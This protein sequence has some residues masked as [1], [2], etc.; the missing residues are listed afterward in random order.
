MRAE[1]QAADDIACLY[2]SQVL[3]EP[4]ECRSSQRTDARSLVRA[5]ASREYIIHTR[6]SRFLTTLAF[7]L[8]SSVVSVLNSLTTIMRAPPSLFGYLI[9]AAP[10]PPSSACNSAGAMTLLLHY[11]LVL[12]GDLPKPN[13][14]FFAALDD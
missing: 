9:F 10:V 8:R 11:R 4:T 1:A 6:A 3:S 5:Q 14:L 7:W 12:S 2:L 13:Y